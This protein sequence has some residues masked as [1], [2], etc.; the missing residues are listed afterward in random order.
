MHVHHMNTAT[1]CP[2]GERLIQGR[3]GLLQR[4]RM[5]CHVLLLE[6]SRGLVL[7]DTGLGLRDIE[8]PQRLGRR[9]LR[10]ASPRLDRA[11][12]AHSQLRALGFSPADV[13]HILLTHLDRDHAGGLADFPR[14][15]VHVDRLEYDAAV[16][17]R[18]PVRPNRY[19]NAHW[20]HGPAWQFYGDGG[21]DWFGFRGVRPLAPDEPDIAVIPLYGHTPGH[22]GIAVRLGDR[23][24]LH[25]GDAYYFHGEIETPARAAPLALRFFQRRA[26]TDRAARI[27]NI[28]RLRALNA[29]CG[30]ALQIFNSHDAA[31]YDR[32]CAGR[33]A[34]DSVKVDG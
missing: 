32:C 5:V 28:E 24:L 8:E 9:W 10:L 18:I 12:T 15:T 3:G 2:R 13:R 23:W 16:A 20:Q 11:E 26:D 6:S 21:E 30:A 29:Q 17:G 33:T 25:A 19:V 22:R 31:D 7:V 1:L 34:G 4:G 14:A 27:A